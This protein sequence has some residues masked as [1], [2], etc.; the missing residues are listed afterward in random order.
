MATFR[1]AAIN[2]QYGRSSGDLQACADLGIDEL[3]SHYLLGHA[4][5]GIS[6]RYI[7][8]L[9]LASGPAMRA[10][11]AKISRRIVAL[12]N[13]TMKSPAL[14]PDSPQ[15]AEVTLLPALP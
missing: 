10:A 12:L 11:Q 14:S 15:D 2:S 13:P 3:I 7:L 4:P 9:I 1:Q 5:A 6:Q 8:K